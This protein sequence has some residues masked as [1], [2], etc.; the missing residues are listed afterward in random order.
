MVLLCISGNRTRTCALR[1]LNHCAR[2]NSARLGRRPSQLHGRRA[3]AR[4][5]LARCTWVHLGRRHRKRRATA[6]RLGQQRGLIGRQGCRCRFATQSNTLRCSRFATIRSQRLLSSFLRS[7]HSS[8]S[9]DRLLALL[10]HVRATCPHLSRVAR[11]V[12]KAG[13]LAVHRALT[14]SVHA[15]RMRAHAGATPSTSRSLVTFSYSNR[16]AARDGV[17]RGAVARTQGLLGR[18]ARRLAAPRRLHG[19][20]VGVCAGQDFLPL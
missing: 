5:L 9:H 7:C 20:A 2:S 15:L 11:S 1:L 10:A 6:C 19:R 8:R 3:R 18:A 17:A 4:A 14:R 16:L 12:V 13:A